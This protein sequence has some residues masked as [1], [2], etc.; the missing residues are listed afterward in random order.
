MIDANKHYPNLT[1]AQFAV[2][3]DDATGAFEDMSR[4]LFS[5]EFLE[6]GVVLHSDHNNPGIEV[7]PILERVHSDGSKQRKISFQAKYF[8]NEASFAKIKDS[9]NQAIKHYGDELDLIYLFCNKTLTTTSKGYK[10][11]VALLE[12]AG[13]ELA[14]ISN[15]EV[16]D[17][18]ANHT[19][20]ASYFFM[21]R[22]RPDDV[23]S[24]SVVKTKI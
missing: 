5:L 17:L 20:I 15:K 16:L 3:N 2:C 22:K 19:E 12:K 4:R 10:D 14:V 11:I 21:P 18:V 7:L 1:W 13:I 24:G 6:K 23:Y 8:E 9:M